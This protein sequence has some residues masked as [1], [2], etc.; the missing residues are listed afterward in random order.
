MI[1]VTRRRLL[2]CLV[3]A[4]APA[5]AFPL[6]AQQPPLSA[7]EFLERIYKTYV[8]DSTKGANGIRLDSAAATRRYFAP[9]LAAMILA[10]NAK[11]AKRGD[12]PTLDGDPFVGHQDWDIANLAVE[13]SEDGTGKATGTVTF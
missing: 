9:D 1:E 4:L 12:V 7:K 10:D 8:G 6:H 11:A 3:M 13:A 5:A 2:S